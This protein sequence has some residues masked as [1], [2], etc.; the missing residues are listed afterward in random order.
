MD[1]CIGS[2]G[3]LTEKIVSWTAPKFQGNGKPLGEGRNDK[4]PGS[5]AG[6]WF[7]FTRTWFKKSVTPAQAQEMMGV[8]DNLPQVQI[9]IRLVDGTRYVKTCQKLANLCFFL[10]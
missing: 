3:E 2:A 8:D 4:L 6:G 10:K 5:K 1:R 7:S 9:Q